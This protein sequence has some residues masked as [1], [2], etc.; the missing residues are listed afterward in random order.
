MTYAPIQPYGVVATKSSYVFSR[1]DHVWNLCQKIFQY[2]CEKNH[3][4]WNVMNR[5]F[6]TNF[7]TPQEVQQGLYGIL[8]IRQQYPE[9]IYRKNWMDVFNLCVNMIRILDDIV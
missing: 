3:P 7:R 6:N 8:Q 5:L 4:A 9:L 1:F 2:R